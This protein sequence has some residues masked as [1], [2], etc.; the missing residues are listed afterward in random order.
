[1]KTLT[2]Q[3]I[4]SWDNAHFLH[5]WE[6]MA[7]HGQLERTSIEAANGIYV[8]DQTG[9]RLIDGPG[10]MWCVQIGYGRSEMGEAMSEQARQMAYFSPFSNTSSVSAR[11]AREIADRTP[12]DLNHVL[13]T[14]G[15]STA[16]DS[17]IRFI[18]FR[19]NILGRPEKKIV[20]SRQ[21]A[22]HGS[23]YLSASVSGK[24]R[25]R[26]WFDKADEL[27]HFLP[28]VNPWTRPADMSVEAFCDARVAD[29]ETAITTLGADNVAAFI[30][31]PILASGGVI[32]PPQG[33]QRR[34]LDICRS[35]DVLYISDEVVTGFGRLGHWF[36]SEAVFD[37]VPD[38]IT[39]AKGM[40]SGYVPMGAAILSDRLVN[41]IS[42]ENARGATF[43]NGFT[44]SGH[45][46]GAAAALKNIEIIEREGINEHVREITPLFQERLRAL[47][48]L[49][50]VG[51]TRGMGLMGCVDCSADP[52][53]SD[54]LAL[55][56]AIGGRIDAHCQ[57]LGLILRPIVSM[58]VFS[59]PL[60]ITEGQCNQMFDILAEGIRRT[61]DDMVR[62]GARLPDRMR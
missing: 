22:Y 8:T 6:G 29:L 57:E 20:I 47:G 54:T 40:T 9:R 58:C 49:P 30:A 11:L 38:I 46:V 59:P 43:S 39:C 5:P 55:D 37:I 28:N 56:F 26:L 33:Y 61:T 44:Y 32:V 45:P 17:A 27:A 21:K 51:D 25:D 53:A 60:V 50:L 14:T 19:N 13:F 10:G 52:N 24:E 23:T 16:V 3:E 2:N 42:G 31:E 48:E 18:H 15:G 36:A 12:G 62:E 7:D 41:E 34:C 1:M 4:N 35:H